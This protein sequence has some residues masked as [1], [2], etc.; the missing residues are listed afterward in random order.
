MTSLDKENSAIFYSILN[1]F[2]IER[3]LFDWLSQFEPLNIYS[4]VQKGIYLFGE[5]AKDKI[6]ENPYIYGESIDLSFNV[7]D[8]IAFSLGWQPGHLE[9]RSAILKEAIKRVTNSGSSY[10]DLS[11]FKSM[12]SKISVSKIYPE[13]LEFT[14][15]SPELGDVVGAAL[16]DG[17]PVVYS[18]PLMVAEK[19]ISENIYRLS[20]N[21]HTISEDSIKSIIED[22]EKNNGV[23]YGLDQKNAIMT[24]VKPGVNVI[25]GGPGTGKTFTVAGIL[26]AFKRLHKDAEI[27][28]FAPTGRAAQRLSESR[29]EERRVGKECRS[30]WSPY[31]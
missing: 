4:A 11:S 26:E 17:K 3:E 15:I 21:K 14:N 22:I 30:R 12:F 2:I 27:K 25:T 10:A 8:K 20:D 13:S 6:S 29:S 31:H 18:T 9:R 23:V 5:Y 16:L 19:R 24:G 7:Q 1:N 28:L